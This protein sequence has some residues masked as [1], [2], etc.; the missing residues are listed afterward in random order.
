MKNSKIKKE[1]KKELFKA[2]KKLGNYGD[3]AWNIDV[4]NLPSNK[5]PIKKYVVN[6]YFDENI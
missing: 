3:V 4:V 2:I 5:K 6:I 1:F